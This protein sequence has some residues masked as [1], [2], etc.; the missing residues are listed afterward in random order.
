MYVCVCKAVTENQ[1]R[2]AVADGVR[3]MRELSL[4]TGC[5]TRC[6]SCARFAATVLG[7]ALAETQPRLRLVEPS[8]V[9]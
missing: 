9:A 5:S 2:A 1:I 4:R 6:G 3:N 8:R 7:E